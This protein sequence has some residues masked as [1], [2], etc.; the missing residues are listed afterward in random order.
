MKR[1]FLIS[2]C[3]VAG[4]LFSCGGGGVGV[5]HRHYGPS[6]WGAAGGYYRDTVIVV[7][8]EREPEFEATPLPSGPEDSFPDMGM[9]DVDFD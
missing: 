7:P 8:P 3:G 2:L 6:P 1:F 9:P 4:L 5:Y